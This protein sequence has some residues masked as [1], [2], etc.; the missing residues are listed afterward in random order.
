MMLNANS[1]N[2]LIRWINRNV[3]RTCLSNHRGFV[4]DSGVGREQ[5]RRGRNDPDPPPAC[6]FSR[7][8][9][10]GLAAGKSFSYSLD[11]LLLLLLHDAL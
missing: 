9:P 6:S 10:R 7:A 8:W 11:F 1:E 3:E 2:M 4:H 5:V